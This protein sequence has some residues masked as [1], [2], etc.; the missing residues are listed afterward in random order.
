MS[1]SRAI[2]IVVVSTAAFGRAGA[3]PA[4][5][6]SIEHFQDCTGY[7]AIIWKA[8]GT[9]EFPVDQVDKIEVTFPY[10]RELAFNIILNACEFRDH[11]MGPESTPSLQVELLNVLW[12]QPDRVQVFKNLYRRGNIAGKLYALV[13]LYDTDSR[14]FARFARSLKKTEAMV[15]ANSGC[16]FRLVSLS[17]IIAKIENGSLTAAFRKV[18]AYM[19]WLPDAGQGSSANNRLKQ[20]AR[21]RSAADARLRAR[22]VA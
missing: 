21:G 1:L 6:S 4:W 15:V 7:E 11:A 2:T 22:A 19:T 9:V 10:S 5:Y 8:D 20:T 16:Y 18:G 3:A 13:G 17:D 14:Q 12:H